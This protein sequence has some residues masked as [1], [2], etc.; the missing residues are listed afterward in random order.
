MKR[1]KNELHKRRTKRRI[2]KVPEIKGGHDYPA[3]Q[4]K[5]TRNYKTALESYLLSISPNIIQKNKKTTSFRHFNFKSDIFVG[6]PSNKIECI[7]FQKIIPYLKFG[8]RSK[9]IRDN[10]CYV[11]ER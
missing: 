10:E 1:K 3:P 8:A 2:K 11:F 7:S 6:I 9:C 4:N 5:G